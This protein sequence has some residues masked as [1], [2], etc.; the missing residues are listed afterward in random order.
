[1]SEK[2]QKRVLEDMM[3]RPIP[4]KWIGIVKLQ[5]VREGKVLYGT[6]RFTSA[7]DAVSMVRP[8][9]AQ[10]DREM[11]VVMSVNTRLEPLA[12]EIVAVGGVDS[13]NVDIKNIFKHALLNNASYIICFNNHPTGDPTP[14]KEDRLFTKRLTSAGQIL[15][16]PVIDHI[17]MGEETFY[18]F[19]EYG[20]LEVFPENN[21]VA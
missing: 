3:K 9:F 4:R 1:M 13:C 18:S 19:K 6:R 12:L 17:I 21:P 2:Y 7:V 5:M 16:L 20:D 8:I 15:N 11:M 10:S 14:S